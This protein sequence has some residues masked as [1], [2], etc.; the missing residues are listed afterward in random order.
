MLP[1]AGLGSRPVHRG[2]AGDDGATLTLSRRTRL[3]F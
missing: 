1:E 2:D 3:E